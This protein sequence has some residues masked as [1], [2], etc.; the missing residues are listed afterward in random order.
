M[1]IKLFATGGTIDCEQIKKGNKYVFSKSHLPAMLKQGRCKVKI[2]REVLM[3]KDSLYMTGKDREKILK[4]CKSCAN[5][6]IIITHGTD[7]MCETAKILGKNLKGKT[8]VLLGAMAPYNQDNSDALF[9]L[10]GGVIAVQSL[11]KGI[12]VIMNGKIFPW[13]NVK[14]N[15]KLG[16]FQEIK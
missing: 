9:N 10:G 2:D 13:N 14:K 15:K 4:R 8:V 5:K 12:Y 7:T 1:K 6:K 3:M 11:R 16:E